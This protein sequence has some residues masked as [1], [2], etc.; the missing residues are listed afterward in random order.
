[1]LRY[2]RDLWNRGIALVA[3]VDEAGR[4]PLAGPVVAA[5]VVFHPHSFLSEVNDSKQLSPMRRELLFDA[6]MAEAAGVGIGVVGHELIDQVN[7]LNAT[8]LAMHKAIQRLSVVPEY[9]LVDGNRFVSAGIP[10]VTIVGGDAS[11]HCIAAAS[12]IA[13]VAR[14][15]MMLEYDR[16][17]PGYGFA[18]HK[19]YPTYEHREAIKRL[20]YCDI[21]RRTF[22]VR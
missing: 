4:G 14:D 9:L 15:R 16:Q 5:A 10:F 11:S 22:K 19:G 13:K 20:G 8:F 7:I 17:F 18:K 12:I 1:M 21:H 6:I 2:E 3:G